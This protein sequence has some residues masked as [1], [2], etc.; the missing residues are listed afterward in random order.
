MAGSPGGGPVNV[1][2]VLLLYFAAACT[3]VRVTLTAF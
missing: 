1:L 3:T 2:H